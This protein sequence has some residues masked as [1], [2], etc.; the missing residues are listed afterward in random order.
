MKSF[1]YLADWPT[2]EEI[3][4]AR[5]MLHAWIVSGALDD[6]GHFEEAFSRYWLCERDHLHGCVCRSC[7]TPLDHH[8]D[9]WVVEPQGKTIT[10]DGVKAAVQWTETGPLWSAV[11]LVVIRQAELLGR[12]AESYLLK[13]LEEPATYVRYVLWTERPNQ[14]WSTIVSRCQR[15]TVRAKSSSQYPADWSPQR[16]R[17]PA[18]LNVQTAVW[19]AQYAR[20]RYC[21]Q[22][23]P[24]WLAWWERWADVYDHL[25][26]NANPE[27]LWAEMRWTW[28][29]S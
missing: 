11:K 22:Q 14:L 9:R 6:L 8:P 24:Q 23:D 21:E 28:P 12:E 5:P 29:A 13:P 15:W 1:S 4:R 18:D 26:H 27:L 20:D 19:A 7:H 16:L 17:G 10:R 2:L 3:V 25:Q